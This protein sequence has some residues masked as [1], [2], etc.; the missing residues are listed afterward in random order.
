MSHASGVG[1]VLLPPGLP[2]DEVLPQEMVRH[3]TIGMIANRMRGASGFS[4]KDMSMVTE[5]A[6]FYSIE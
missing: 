3:A 6:E 1:G 4:L 5:T 2:L